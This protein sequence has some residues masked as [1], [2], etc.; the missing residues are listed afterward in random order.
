M[1]ENTY[2]NKQISGRSRVYTVVLTGIMAALVMAATS[3]FRIPVPATNGYIHLGDALIFISV[4]VLGRRNG[5]IAGATGSALADLLGGY[6]HWVPWTFVIK[7]L[8]AFVTGSVLMLERRNPT[9]K[10]KEKP[11]L[12]ETSS[13]PDKIREAIA[14]TAGGL[15]MIA[16]YF[17]AHIVIYGTIAAPLAAL[18]GN[19]IQAGAGVIIAEAVSV[20]LSRSGI[21]RKIS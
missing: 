18:P 7:G 13:G 14:F 1:D 19:I 10:D 11:G 15:V 20:P 5:T 8:M 16:G 3:F 17:I 4:L 6:V 9:L 21:I 12:T 2:M